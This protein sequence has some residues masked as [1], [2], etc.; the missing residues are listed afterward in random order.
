MELHQELDIR[1]IEPS[2][3]FGKLI[4]QFVFL[5]QVGAGKTFTDK[6]I[7]D[8]YISLVIHFGA[9]V[10][11]FSGGKVLLLPRFFIVVPLHRSLHIHVSPFCDAM[12]VTFHTTKFARLFNLNLLQQ[13]DTP[14][15]SAENIFSELELQEMSALRTDGQRMNFIEKWLS[16]KVSFE[17]YEDDEIDQVFEELMQEHGSC[18]IQS[19]LR[20]KKID[21]R[22]FRRKFLQRTGMNAKGLC[23]IA[24]FHY[25]WSGFRVRSISDIQTM[26]FD[27]GFYD[28]SH[29]IN[30]FKNF[31]GESPKAF[32]SRNQEAVCF[33]SGK[34]S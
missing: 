23:R 27:G 18:A 11:C 15:L 30:D 25:L 31:I 4:R 29:M 21:P 22:T 24:R 17:E 2:K 32:F 3:K 1:C 28:Q 19:I 16:S 20:D 33:M 6:Y 9:D 14:F 10:H 5:K 13:R 7:P 26:I 12:V 34:K 8:G